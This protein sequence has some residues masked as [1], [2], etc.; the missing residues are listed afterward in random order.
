MGVIFPSQRLF[1]PGQEDLHC[2]LSVRLFNRVL[3]LQ[4]LNIKFS[5][6]SYEYY[7]LFC[8]MFLLERVIM[9]GTKIINICC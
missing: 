6:R 7:T 8:K 9:I 3:H 5:N 2:P 4:V 1:V